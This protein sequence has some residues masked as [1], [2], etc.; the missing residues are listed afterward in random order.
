MNYRWYLLALGFF[1]AGL[2]MGAAFVMFGPVSMV[3]ILGML[4]MAFSVAGGAISVW[5]FRADDPWQWE[6]YRFRIARMFDAAGAQL[7]RIRQ[8]LRQLPA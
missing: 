4:A 6:L 8:E 3:R 5:T 2:L 7:R 1:A